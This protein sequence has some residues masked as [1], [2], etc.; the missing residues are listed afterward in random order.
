MTSRDSKP[1]LG[2]EQ[3]AFDELARARPL[4]HPRVLEAIRA[5][6]TKSE[7]TSRSS[8][9]SR[10]TR[11]AL[12]ALLLFGGL[13]LTSFGKMIER[14]ALLVVALAL[15]SLVLGTGLLS[16]FVPGPQPRWGL[17]ARRWFVGASIVAVLG[18]Y[19]LFADHFADLHGL[20]SS[21]GGHA[22]GCLFRSLLTGLLCA[23]SL[24]IVWR[25]TD[26][27]TPTWTG[28]LLGLV[29]GLFGAAAASVSCDSTEGFHLLVGHGLVT[30]V[31][32]MLF[33]LLGKKWLAP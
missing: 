12:S 6:V 33:A 5:N 26:P 18:G 9:L 10:R 3:G 14:G 29:G 11:L 20:T 21:D 28:A 13:S 2:V 32:T 31:L 4:P 17:G 30:L 22:S 27:F 25:R 15:A 23:S 24:V 7:A 19:A 16:S 8:P 1:S